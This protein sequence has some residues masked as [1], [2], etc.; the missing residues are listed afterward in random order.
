MFQRF[1]SLHGA[2]SCIP[3]VSI[4]S[5]LYAR[6]P[7]LIFPGHSGGQPIKSMIDG[8]TICVRSESGR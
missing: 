5:A 3:D 4:L 7:E 2:F 8:W 6:S 1:V